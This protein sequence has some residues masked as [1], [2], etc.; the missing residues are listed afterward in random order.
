M[1]AQLRL[2]FGVSLFLGMSGL[3]PL[4]ALASLYFCG[5]LDYLGGALPLL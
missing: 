1:R 5:M 3:A 2:Y 4:L